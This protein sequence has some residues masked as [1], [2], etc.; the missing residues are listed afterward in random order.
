[1]RFN[2]LA[3]QKVADKLAE[4]IRR[5]SVISSAA[6]AVERYRLDESMY[7]SSKEVRGKRVVGFGR[8]LL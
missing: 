8:R 7:H 5:D 6:E 3:P 1:V 4:I 2:G